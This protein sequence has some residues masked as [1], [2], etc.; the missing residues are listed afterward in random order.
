MT[1]NLTVNHGAQLVREARDT[2]I[3]VD[4]F[5]AFNQW[6][7]AYLVARADIKVVKDAI[8]W[9]RMNMGEDRFDQAEVQDS[10]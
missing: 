5:R 6:M 9:T 8:V 4:D 1:A 2:V 3:D 7:L 10:P